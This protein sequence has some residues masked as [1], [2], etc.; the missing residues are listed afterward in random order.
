L[1]GAVAWMRGR[2]VWIDLRLNPAAVVGASHVTMIQMS[3]T[4]TSPARANPAHDAA[5]LGFGYG[6]LIAFAVYLIFKDNAGHRGAPGPGMEDEP[7][8][9][10]PPPSRPGKR[11]P[12]PVAPE[13]S[14]A[15]AGEIRDFLRAGVPGMRELARAYPVIRERYHAGDP[16]GWADSCNAAFCGYGRDIQRRLEECEWELDRMDPC[17]LWFVY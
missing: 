3:E 2:L 4:Q 11:K 5:A 1:A 6:M 14:E 8:E 13:R 16:Q 9:P 7:S 15:C 12:P 17:E 10:V